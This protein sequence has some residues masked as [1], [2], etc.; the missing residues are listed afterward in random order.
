[1]KPEGKRAMPRRLRHGPERFLLLCAALAAMSCATVPSPSPP[2]FDAASASQSRAPGSLIGALYLRT[3]PSRDEW[4]MLAAA[5]PWLLGTRIRMRVLE[6]EGYAAWRRSRLDSLRDIRS[7]K[8]V[9]EA[10]LPE[11]GSETQSGTVFVPVPR[12]EYRQ[13]LTW[14]VFAKGTELRRDYTPSRGKA[15]EMPFITALASL[16]Y[17]V[18]VPD[19]SGMGEGRGVHEYCVPD[20]LAD[21]ALDGLAAARQW[22][23]ETMS[24][25]GLAYAEN[26]RL[27]VMGYSEGGLAAMGT[28]KAIVDDRIPTPGLS[29]EAVY[30]MGAPL[31]LVI[32]VP[33]LGPKP[34]AISH[35]EYQVFLGLGW[36]RVY[37]DEVKPAEIFSPRTVDGI[38]PLFDGTRRDSDIERRISAIV[39]KKEGEVTDEDIFA[40]EYLS[41]LRHDPTSSA[42]Y[43]LQSQARLDDWTPPSGVPIILA[44]TPTDD[45]VPFANS[46]DEYAWAL[47]QDPA[48][49]LS[50]VRLSS[51]DHISAGV[52]AY[53]YAVV[54]LDRREGA[55]R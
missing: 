47:R 15:L 38:L 41:A 10:R 17:A 4:L 37:P 23:G 34:F 28:L 31:D 52:E 27:V 49:K 42:Y 11:G 13:R 50:L 25:S 22:L 6:K 39:G 51:A 43:R 12:R 21:S 40:P 33:N 7:T 2:Y 54:D 19:Y 35:P 9:F 32:E 14:I 26:G 29:L 24:E 46:E 5:S 3:I 36:A 16:G 8:I 1:M 18:W 55:V 45:I 53:L 30:A 48:A 20:S 44:A